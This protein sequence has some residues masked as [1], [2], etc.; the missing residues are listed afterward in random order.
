M[1]WSLKQVS[2]LLPLQPLVANENQPI[3]GLLGLVAQVCTLSLVEY[4][5]LDAIFFIFFEA[6]ILFH[7]HG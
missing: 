2:S 7:N 1:G 6:L 4:L 5:D 3:L